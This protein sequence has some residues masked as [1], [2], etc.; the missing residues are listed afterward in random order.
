MAGAREDISDEVREALK[1]LEVR[2]HPTPEQILAAIKAM[3]PE[4]RMQVW[5]LLRG[6][7][8]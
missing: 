3:T 1:I 8:D 4:Q 2:L 6:V 7:K 5:N